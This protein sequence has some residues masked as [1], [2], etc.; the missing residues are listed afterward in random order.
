MFFLKKKHFLTALVLLISIA[1]LAFPA[2]PDLTPNPPRALLKKVKQFA[3]F[4][5]K[6]LEL[7]VNMIITK[8]TLKCIQGI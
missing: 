6:K 8:N 1:G 7:Y 3:I 5:Y 2:N 4:R